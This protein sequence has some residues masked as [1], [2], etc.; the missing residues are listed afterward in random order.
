MDVTPTAAGPLAHALRA[1]RQGRGLS[2][3]QL[4]AN[5]V[6]PRLL[7]ELERGKRPHVSFDT[8]TR[9]LHLVGVS[10]SFEPGTAPADE[11]A[12]TRECSDHRSPTV[13]ALF[14][15]RS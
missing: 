8:A 6:S 9:L 1:A 10:L 4:E 11:T 13:T 3:A 14:L 2:I 7:T 15:A 5:E 12:R